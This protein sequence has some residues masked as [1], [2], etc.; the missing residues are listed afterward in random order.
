VYFDSGFSRR[1]RHA[2]ASGFFYAN[3]RFDEGK[4]LGSFGT[5][6]FPGNVS[7]PGNQKYK[8]ALRKALAKALDHDVP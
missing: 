8:K 5:V 1:R 3:Y 6:T 7:S 4:P 2:A